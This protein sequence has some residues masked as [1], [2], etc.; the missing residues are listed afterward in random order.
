MAKRLNRK[1]VWGWMLFDWAAQPYF[2]LVVTFIFGPYFVS[3]VV[4]DPVRGQSIWAYTNAGAGLLIACLAPVLG[5]IADTVGRRKLWLLVF[6]ALYVVSAVAL[7]WAL[8]GSS[9]LW[10]IIIAFSVGLLAI[11][12]ATA[13]TNAAL[14]EIAP[15]EEIGRLSGAGW[16]T[17]YVGG[18]VALFL[19]LLLLA[20]NDQGVTLLGQPPIGDLDPALREGTRSVA[21]MAALWYIV[22]V[23]PFFLFVPD[24]PRPAPVASAVRSGLRALGQTL[25]ALPQNASLMNYLL[26]AMF[27]R[28][29]LNGIFVFG[30]IYAAGVL[31]WST[32]ERGI[33]GILAL[34][35]GIFATIGGGYLDRAYGPKPVVMVSVAIL[36]LT[37]LFAI[38]ISRDSLLGMS[39]PAGSALPDIAFYLCGALIGSAGGVLQASS[40]TLLV[41]Q[42]DPNRM[43][44][45]FGLYALSGK[46]TAFLAPFLIGVATD[47]SGT[48]QWGIVPV[49][50]LF[51]IGWIFLM[52]VH[53]RRRI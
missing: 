10:F 51:V 53:E 50:G 37:C 36:T 38:S 46:A 42:A 1:A 24:P 48:Q 13:F 41:H 12:I 29:A 52:F 14:P 28:D 35:C 11:E 25:R 44:E 8:P 6:S 2:T 27:Y 47:L 21:P 4:G 40:R 34:V 7:W 31:D 39:L 9:S 19:A 18:V 17:G 30:A 43:T 49:I 32:T 22:F 3:A 15:R 16:A 33:F 5:A 45:A 20:E 23:I 26:S